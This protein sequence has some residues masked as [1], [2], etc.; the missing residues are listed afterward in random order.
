[1][2]VWFLEGFVGRGRALQRIRVNAFPFQVGRQEGLG[3]MLDSAGISRI[4]AEL[5]VEGENLLL[6]DLES[7]NGTFINR[8][9]LTGAKPI[10]NGDIIHFADEEFRLLG[11]DKITGVNLKMTQQGIGALP[12]NLPKGA[13]ELQQ[14]LLNHQVKAVFQPIVTS[15]DNTIHAY[16][17]LGRGTHPGLSESPGLLFNIA[18]SMGLAV[19][20]SELLRQVGVSTAHRMDGKSLFFSNIHP[21]EMNDSK[22]LLAELDK[23]YRD[24]EGLTLVVEIHESAVADREVLM[25]FR[26]FLHERGGKIAYDDFGRGQARVMELAEVPPDYVKLDME[27]IVDIDKAATAK[28]QM[29]GMLCKFA[30]DNGILVVAEGVNSDGEVAFCDDNQIALLQGYRFGR[31]QAL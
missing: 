26:D 13:R 9:P 11:E 6:R 19:Q 30:N 10:R 4:H 24:F 2:K 16:E 1:M 22:R 23:M 29:V 20:L 8:E 25:T 5:I 3:L 12:E 7:T 14:L 31:P 15:S 17:M 28:Q 27:L 18:E 21:N